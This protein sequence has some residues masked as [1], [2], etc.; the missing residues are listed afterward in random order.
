MHPILSNNPE[1]SPNHFSRPCAALGVCGFPE[2]HPGNHIPKHSWTECLNP[3]DCGLCTYRSQR[4]LARYGL[5]LGDLAR[6]AAANRAKLDARRSP[7]GCI[8][9]PICSSD[10]DSSK[11]SHILPNHL[12]MILLEITFRRSK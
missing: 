10:T 1:P 7:N 2:N 8:N 6:M 4:R 11:T 3:A 12:K 5:T 9:C